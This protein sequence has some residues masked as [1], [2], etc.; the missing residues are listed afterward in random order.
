MLQ[1][2]KSLLNLNGFHNLY[3]NSR[4]VCAVNDEIFD[5]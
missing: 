4:M 1:S 2:L 5:R 3:C